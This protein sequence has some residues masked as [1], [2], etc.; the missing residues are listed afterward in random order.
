[1]NALA[2]TGQEFWQEAVFPYGLKQFDL[3]PVWIAVLEEAEAFLWHVHPTDRFTAQNVAEYSRRLFCV[4]DPNRHVVEA[5]REAHLDLTS[6]TPP[7]TRLPHAL[8]SSL[9]DGRSMILLATAMA[10]MPLGV[11]HLPQ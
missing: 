10:G 4:M 1:M 8:P 9:M 7:N 11:R 2:P 3:H 5:L 6:Q